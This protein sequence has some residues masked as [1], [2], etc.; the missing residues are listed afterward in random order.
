MYIKGLKL[1]DDPEMVNAGDPCIVEM[2]NFGNYIYSIKKVD[3]VTKTKIVVGCIDFKKGR[4]KTDDFGVHSTYIYK[5]EEWAAQK[6]RDYNKKFNTL[7]QLKSL[8]DR[9]GIEKII[10]RMTDE[11]MVNLCN[12]FENFK[13]YENQV[14]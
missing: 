9:T 13:K 6:I 5:Y 11:D 12:I 7:N 1:L 3:R 4:R 2:S 14:Y 10:S 8:L